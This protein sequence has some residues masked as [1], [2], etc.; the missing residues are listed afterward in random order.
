M[1]QALTEQIVYHI[2]AN[3]GVLPA[4]F[5]NWNR[6]QSLVDK[7]YLLPEKLS[8]ETEDGQ[9]LRKNI[10]GCQISV[11]D[12]KT[13]KVLLV[14]CSQDKSVPEFCLVINLQDNP[15][16]GLYL[17][18]NKL[19]DD[20]PDPEPMIAVSLNHKDWM[21]CNIFLQ[22]TFLAGMEQVKDLGHNWSKCTDYQIQYGALQSFINFHSTFNGGFDEGQEG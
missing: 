18:F 20:P 11:A 9:T 5:I 21:I 4:S 7:Q 14:D 1:N 13:I 12:V 17:V 10:Y 22:A 2:L 19:A 15:S 8:F 16:Y 6:T 3:F